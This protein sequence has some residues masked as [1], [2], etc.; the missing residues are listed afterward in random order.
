MP[1]A[2]PPIVDNE[3]EFKGPLLDDFFF[4][5]NLIKGL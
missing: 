5:N 2:R 1:C 4:P 3:E